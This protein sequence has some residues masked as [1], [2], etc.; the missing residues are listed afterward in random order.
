ML[1]TLF[2]PMVFVAAVVVVM[3]PLL[4]WLR[5]RNL[6][7][8][9]PIVDMIVVGAGVALLFAFGILLS[10]NQITKEPTSG[11]DTSSKIAAFVIALHL[12]LLPLILGRSITSARE[13]SRQS[14]E[15]AEEHEKDILLAERTVAGEGSLCVAV[16]DSEEGQLS[17]GPE[18][19]GA[20]SVAGAQQA[21]P[22]HE[23]R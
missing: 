18:A 15:R 1:T 23:T 2:V 10:W 6:V 16:A 4:G 17:L 11:E 7:R 8:F 9:Q 22:R 13:V 19:E 20:L 3:A 21:S 5:S 12:V 14:R